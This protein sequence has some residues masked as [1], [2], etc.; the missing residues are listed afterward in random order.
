[1]KKTITLLVLLFMTATLL[2]GESLPDAPS[3]LMIKNALAVAGFPMASSL[4]DPQRVP[5]QSY[6]ERHRVKLLLI[7]LGIGALI[8]TAIALPMR[9]VHCPP[10]MYEGHRYDGTSPG[11]PKPEGQETPRTR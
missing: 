3:A 6:A 8:G 7:S 1:M 5:V 11:C 10:V 2:P 9:N 4:A